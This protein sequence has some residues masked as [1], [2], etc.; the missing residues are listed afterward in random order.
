MLASVGAGPRLLQVGDDGSVQGWIAQR[1]VGLAAGGAQQVDGLVGAG[2]EADGTPGLDLRDQQVVEGVPAL[3]QY[4]DGAAAGET[5]APRL[6]VAD[7]EEGTAQR[8]LPFQHRLHL[9]DGVA[10]DAAAAHRT[11][12]LP[13]GVEGHARPRRA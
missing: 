2:G 5:G 3:H 6:F 11:G 7:A 10:V 4:V 12:D 13:L 8:E 9:R 1:A